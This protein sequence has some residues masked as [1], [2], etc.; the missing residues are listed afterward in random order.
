[1]SQLTINSITCQYD[2]QVIIEDLSFTLKENEIVALLGPS[3]CGK[4]TLLKAVAG[5]LPVSQGK[6]HIGERLV[7]EAG[8][9][10]PSEKR[11]IAM[12]FQDYA[13]FPHLNVKK[14]IAFGLNELT[15]AEKDLRVAEMLKLVNLS[16]FADRYPHELSGGQQQR[17]AIARALAY[18][19]EI[20]LLDEPFS[21]IDSQ[22]RSTIMV[23]IRRILKQQKTTAIFVTHSKDEAFIFAD[24]IAIFKT[25]KITQL[26]SAKHIYT[27]PNSKYV[28]DFLGK[29][30]Y[31]P[32]LSSNQ[33][34][35][36]TSLGFISSNL[37][38]SLNETK[39]QLLLRPEQIR[40]TAMDNTDKGDLKIVNRIFCGSYWRY[41]V[42]IR[43]S[44]HRL[45]V[46]SSEELLVDSQVIASVEPH[47]LVL[48]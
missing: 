35:V 39:S 24:Q 29:S 34:G 22:S 46:H 42:D 43:N 41:Q 36:Q 17:V 40:L 27:N 31:L 38:L 30:N 44:N 12:I 48:F 6:I 19:P 10:L 7:S 23:D 32:I 1:M 25:G 37:P 16:A 15:S 9:M 11:K 21:N 5:L 45:E 2:Q 8:F 14:N 3:G 18:Q 13:L 20:V 28:A 26:G 47:H 4:T 33:Q